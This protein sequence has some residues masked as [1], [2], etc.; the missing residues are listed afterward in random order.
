MGHE[1]VLFPTEKG[2]RAIQRN[3]PRV[4]A[5]FS[6]KLLEIFCREHTRK[7]FDLFFA[8]LMDSMLGPSGADRVP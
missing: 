2:R 4:R 8:Y 6:Q 1:V 3:D 7:P 5:A